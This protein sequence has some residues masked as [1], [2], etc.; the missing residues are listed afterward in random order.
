MSKRKGS[1]YAI[2]VF[3]VAAHAFGITSQVSAAPLPSPM[4]LVH[5]APSDARQFQR[6]MASLASQAHVALV[7]EGVPLK[8][9]LSAAEAVNLTAEMPLDQAVSKMAAAYDYDT[10]HQGNVFVLI[11]RYSD[12]HDLPCVTLAECRRAADDLSDVLNVFN[13]NFATSIY[14]NGPDGR[15]DAVVSFF[16]SLS[17]AQLQSAQNKTLYYGSLAPSQQTIIQKLFLYQYVQSPLDE[18]KGAI[19]YLDYTPQSAVK[20][21][22]QDGYSG[23]FMEVP[24]LYAGGPPNLLSLSGGLTPLDRPQP[25]MVRALPLASADAVPLQPT[26]LRKLTSG[27]KPV[28]GKLP[29]VDVSLADKPVTAAGIDNAETMAVLKALAM[30]YGLDLEA[31]VGERPR[32]KPHAVLLPTNLREIDAAVWASLPVSYVRA[33]HIAPAA[34]SIPAK[35]SVSTPAKPSAAVAA[36][37]DWPNQLRLMQLPMSIQQEANS[38][39]LLAI[40]LP[41]KKQGLSV[42][43]PV[44]SLGSST[45]AA[46]AISLMTRLIAT[47]HDGFSGSPHQSVLNCVDNM[48]QTVIYTVQG[49]DAH[50]GSQDVPS[51][52]L[53]GTDLDTKQHVGL[54]GV[55]Y[56]GNN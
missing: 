2:A 17:P 39:L 54:G 14:A 30:L 31:P 53:E 13:P 49:E 56:F 25:S 47:L 48:N 1:A 8:P 43:V 33:L 20:A 5:L 52:Y 4:P 34:A 28:N 37:P 18:V 42:R 38:R 27:L 24:N 51:L 35:P 32:L 36:L 55:R 40:Q 19:N 23:L 50:F 9:A 26:T 15:R 21:R 11:K 41:L 22:N 6:A 45:Q 12:S 44:K 46:L 29:L 16:E 10:Q 3:A 7:A